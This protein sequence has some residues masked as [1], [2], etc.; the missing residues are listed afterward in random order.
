M[1]KSWLVQDAKARVSELLEM[2][3]NERPQVVTKR[4]AGAAVPVPL[5]AWQRVKRS[6]P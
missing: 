2:C 3:L 4:G 1:M 6:A 5:Q